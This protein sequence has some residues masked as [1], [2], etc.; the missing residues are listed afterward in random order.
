MTMLSRVANRVYW[1]ARYLE[2]AENTA[3]LINVNTHLLLDLPKKVRLGWGPIV[4]IT[5]RRDYFFS[6]YEEADERS[7]IR[8]MVSDTRNPASILSA[9]NMARENTRTIRDIIPREAWEQVNTLHLSTKTNAKSVITQR[10]RYDFLR[11][12]ILGVQTISGMLAGT[13]THDEGYSFLRMGRNLE[14]ADMTT[15]IIDVRSA[16]LLPDMPEDL[17]PFENLQWVS[18]LKSLTAYQMYRREMRQRIRRVDV[19][20]FLLQEEHF[21]RS[22]YHT[23][24]QVSAC[25]DNLPRN[26][27]TLQLLT[28]QQ[29]KLLQTK[30]QEFDQE[31]LHAFIDELQV[32]VI[33]VNDSISETYF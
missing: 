25:L 3:R 26:E 31:K 17:T 14:R 19:L 11:S 27:K 23:S 6:L 22:F 18:V 10:H 29:K 12:V 7:V 15:R 8:F 20:K 4:D 28:K 24:R 21:P 1:M 33:K 9:L 13:M 5:S 30:L 16:T 32:G 2:R